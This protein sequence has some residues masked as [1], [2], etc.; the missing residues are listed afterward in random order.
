M[1]PPVV[2]TR[3]SSPSASLIVMTPILKAATIGAC[4]A[5][6]PK[7]PSQAGT[8][9]E[10]TWSDENK[11]RSGVTISTENV[12]AISHH[13]AR[14]FAA[15]KIGRKRAELKLIPQLH[16]LRVNEQLTGMEH[17]KVLVTG[18]MVEPIGEASE[19]FAIAREHIPM[20]WDD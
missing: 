16:F 5:I 7:L 17:M 10:T 15:F 14:K 20:R 11:T 8:V 1:K 12:R 18:V 6:T 9:K 3:T 2:E 4:I 19:V 13:R